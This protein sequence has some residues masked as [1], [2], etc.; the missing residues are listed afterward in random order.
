MSKKL[1]CAA[2][3]AAALTLGFSSAARAHVVLENT[4]AGADSYTRTTFLVPHG[5]EGAATT[6]IRVKLPG[7]IL[8]AK[9]QPK[10]GWRVEVKKTAL[11]EPVTGPHGASFTEQVSEII[12]RG[13]NLPDAQFDEFKIHLRLPAFTEKTVLHFPVLQSCGESQTA[14]TEIAEPG[15][16]R[17]AH[18]APALTVTPAAQSHHAH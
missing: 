4:R 18:P 12:W 11:P 17:P 2:L 6:A 9:P 15:G 8:T 7:G 5:C 10:A 13:G 1:S 16:K 3:C 14:W